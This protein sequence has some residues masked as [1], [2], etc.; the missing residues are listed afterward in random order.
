MTATS[1]SPPLLATERAGLARDSALAVHGLSVGFRTRHGR[2]AALTDVDIEVPAGEFLVVAGE[3]GSGKS[4]LAG[5]VLG[6][7]PGNAHVRGSIR[8]AGQDLSS[9]DQQALARCRRERVTYIPQSPAT[10]LNPVRR[11]GSL[12]TELARTRGL[13]PR[14]ASTALRAAL[15]DLGLDYDRLAGC[16]P[17]QL[18]GGMQQRVLNALAMIGEPALVIADEP[19]SGLDADLVDATA[20]QLRRLVAGGAGVLVITHD[21]RLAQRLG[22][23]LAL[24]YGGYVV[25]SG[26]AGEFFAN[27]AHPYGEGLLGALPER[28]GRPVPGQPVELTAPPPGCPFE[29]RCAVRV[30]ACAGPVPELR[31]A[32]TGSDRATVVRCYRHGA[33]T[34]VASGGHGGA[35]APR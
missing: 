21:L 13:S 3:S 18:S 22:G 17:H 26:P 14:S 7:L 5:A 28:G 31:P 32:A 29:P 34:G 12:L 11:I 1:A 23:R 16:Y 8:I 10:A 25:E 19:T 27:P 2:V 30:A 4:V 15:A 35:D 6:A 33:D 24:L 9:L 20:D